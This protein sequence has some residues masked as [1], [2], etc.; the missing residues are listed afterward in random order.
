MSEEK[1]LEIKEKATDLAKNIWLAGLGA[2]GKAVDEAQ[3]TYQKVTEKVK[4]ASESANLF[5]DLVEKGKA[6]EGTTQEKLLEV[7]E[8]ANVNLEERLAKVKE[9]M[10]FNF[11][12]ADTKSADELLEEISQKLDLV[13]AAVDKTPAKESVKKVAV[14]KAVVKDA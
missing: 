11:K 14:K 9:S 1:T 7:K 2:Y 5:D 10:T 8:K 6:L 4:V 12:K 13:L 3:G